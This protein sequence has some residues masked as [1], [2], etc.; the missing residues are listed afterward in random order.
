MDS[1]FAQSICVIGYT[2]FPLVLAALMSALH[3]PHRLAD[4]HGQLRNSIPETARLGRWPA[5]AMQVL[6]KDVYITVTDDTIVHC[7]DL[8]DGRLYHRPPDAATTDVKKGA[9]WKP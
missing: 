7:R 3:L 5:F 1:S 4:I 8:A 9:P 2:L 6:L